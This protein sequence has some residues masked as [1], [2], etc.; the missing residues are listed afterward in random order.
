MHEYDDKITTIYR[1]TEV[2]IVVK[3][4]SLDLYLESQVYKK[5]LEP[6]K[7]ATFPTI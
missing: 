6:L 1:A 5:N 4:E 2:D 3:K 7:K